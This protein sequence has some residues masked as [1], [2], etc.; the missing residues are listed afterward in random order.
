MREARGEGA[1][2]RVYTAEN[3]GFIHLQRK[4]W[5][6]ALAHTEYVDEQLPLAWNLTVRHIAAKTV[7]YQA[8]ANSDDAVLSASDAREIA[9]SAQRTL[10]AMNSNRFDEEELRRLTPKEYHADIDRLIARAKAAHERKSLEAE[11]FLF[12][13]E[14]TPSALR[15]DAGEDICPRQTRFLDSDA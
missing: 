11:G 2:G 1:I 12:A 4:D 8:Q 15:Y 9:C 13:E 7:Y 3:I 14:A 6:R 10:N 5:P